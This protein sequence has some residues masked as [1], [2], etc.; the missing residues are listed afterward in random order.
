MESISRVAL[1]SPSNAK[2][3]IRGQ[4]KSVLVVERV[5]PML[6]A[7]VAELERKIASMKLEVSGMKKLIGE[8]REASN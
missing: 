6:E 1:P 7:H 5:V 8:L 2:T 4:D 3:L